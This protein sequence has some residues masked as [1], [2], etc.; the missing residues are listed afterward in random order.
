M[1]VLRVL[2]KKLITAVP[3]AGLRAGARDWTTANSH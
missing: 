3:V 1:A 2:N